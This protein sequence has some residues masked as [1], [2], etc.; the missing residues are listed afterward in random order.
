MC[1]DSPPGKEWRGCPQSTALA[2]GVW[3][4]CSVS[5]LLLW[6]HGAATQPLGSQKS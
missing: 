1:D 6:V 3:G 2:L 5:G 4:C